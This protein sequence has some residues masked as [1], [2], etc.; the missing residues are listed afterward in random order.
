M[1]NTKK[2]AI[3]I[4]GDN[5]EASL[6]DPILNES[7]KYGRVT[8]K[9][10][11]ADWTSP[12]MNSW[13]DK[14]N[15]YAIKPM[16]KFAYTKGK[17]STDSALIIDAM[18]ILHSKLVDGFCIVSSDSD[19]TSIAN[20]IRE[21]GMFVM[22]IGRFNTPEAFVKACEQFTYTEILTPTQEIVKK[23][24]K[25]KKVEKNGNIIPAQITPEAQELKTKNEIN[26]SKLINKL[27]NKPIDL[28]L[29]DRAF[30]MVADDIT[31]LAL[32]SRL[33]EAI[34]KIDPTFDSRNYGF[35]SFRKFIEA[36]KPVYEV[37]KHDDN[38]TISVKRKE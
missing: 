23:S 16:Q 24:K 6:I 7:A 1:E 5:A 15:K 9:R 33:G 27:T 35:S 25:T 28:S 32:A 4:D 34:R 3:L 11:Y 19:Y 2:I 12:K 36:L 37:V 22:G 14:L 17:N 38:S 31:S 26:L 21:E 10:I 30:D 29:I 20:R 13:K 8:I 18:D